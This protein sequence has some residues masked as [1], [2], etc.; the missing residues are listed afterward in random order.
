L[1][2]LFCVYCI[3][4]VTCSESRRDT[5]METVRID[6][7]IGSNNSSI[8]ILTGVSTFTTK[9]QARMSM[10]RG[11]CQY[12]RLRP[13]LGS[14]LPNSSVMFCVFCGLKVHNVRIFIKKKIF[15]YTVGSVCR[16]KRFTTGWQT[17]C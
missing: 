7:C 5:S 10:F 14:I 11:W 4:I 17:F 6:R 13:C 2:V 16:V 12:S 8:V 15:M 3:N 1:N 9:G